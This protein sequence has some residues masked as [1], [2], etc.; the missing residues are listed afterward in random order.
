MSMAD[1]GI[2]NDDIARRIIMLRE[3]LGMNQSAFATLVGLTQPGLANYESGLRRP[4]IDK[5]IQICLRTGATMD[6]LYR[7]ERSGL[8]QRLLELLPDFA[9]A[10]KKAG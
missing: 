7:G 8:P 3:A 2:A 1:G 4:D 5:A 6:W 10:Q 9:S